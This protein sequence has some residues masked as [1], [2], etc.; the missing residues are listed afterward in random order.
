MRVFTPVAIADMVPVLYA[1]V[2]R[3]LWPAASLSVLAHLIHL[4]RSGAATAGGE[5]GPDS[6]YR[7][8][9]GDVSARS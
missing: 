9:G 1:A 7:L 4:T 6:D 2:D 3:R 5:P 8:A